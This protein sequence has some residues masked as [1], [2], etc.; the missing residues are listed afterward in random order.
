[1]ER[2]V[3]FCGLAEADWKSESDS[4]M[5]A[6][7]GSGSTVGATVATRTAGRL[8]NAWAGA[9]QLARRILGTEPRA[10]KCGRIIVITSV[11]MWRDG[12]RGE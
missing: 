6:R 9:G 4:A 12:E 2:G 11:P 8:A 10:R 1:M 7:A 5:S 3:Q